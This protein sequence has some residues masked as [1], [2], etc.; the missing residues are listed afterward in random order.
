LQHVLRREW[1]EL[2]V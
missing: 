2:R 1:D